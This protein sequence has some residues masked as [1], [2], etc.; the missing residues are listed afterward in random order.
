MKKNTTFTM[1][2]IAKRSQL[3]IIKSLFSSL[4]CFNVKKKVF[5]LYISLVGFSLSFSSD[6]AAF[7]VPAGTYYFDNSQTNWSNVYLFIG[8]GSYVISYQMTSSGNAPDVYS[9]NLLGLW[10]G[11]TGFFFANNSGGVTSGSSSYN[12]NTAIGAFPSNQPTVKSTTLGSAPA[13]GDAFV[14]YGT[15]ANFNMRQVSS[16]A[17]LTAPSAV[18][19][20]SNVMFYIFQDY[21]G[22]LGVTNNSS[23]SCIAT[24]QNVQFNSNKDNFIEMV[25]SNVP[26]PLSV[27]NNCNNWIGAGN[28]A[29]QTSGNAAGARYVTGTSNSKTNATSVT[30]SA[31][32]TS[33]AQGTAS[34]T[35]TASH[36]NNPTSS[37]GRNMYVQYYIGGTYYTSS[38][39]LTGTSTGVSL[40]TS[41]LAAGTY[42]IQS[43]ITDRIV[44]Y[45]TT[46]ITLTVTSTAPTITSTSSSITS[47][48]TQTYK[49]ATI[50]INGTNLSG[51]TTVKIGGSGGTACTNVTV[52]SSTQVT[53]I[54]PDGTSGGTIYVDNGTANTTSTDSYTN[55]GFISTTTGNWGTAS[56]WLGGTAPGTTSEATVANSHTVTLA[57]DATIA[58][59]TINS[60]GIFN[61]SS[62][63]LNIGSSGTITNNGTFTASTSTV[64]FAGAGTIAGTIAFNNLTLNGAVVFS[65]GTTV[66]GTLQLNASG[67]VSTNAPIYGSSSTLIYNQGGTPSFGNEWT[68]NST[69]AGAGVPKNVK[70][71]N[72]TTVNMPNSNRGIA[73]NIEISS[74]TLTL[75][76]TS[77]DIYVAG[78]WKRNNT[79]T[80]FTPNNRAVLFNG[81]GNSTIT[82]SGG[83][84]ETFNYFLIDKTSGNVILDNTVG[85]L[86]NCIVNA[87]AGNVFEIK[88]SGGLDLNGQTF[89]VSGSGGNLYGNGAQRNI[90]GT[91][92]G[93]FSV[94]AAKTVTGFG[95]TFGSNVTLAISSSFTF[96]TNLTIINGT[97]KLLSG[98]SLTNSPSYGNSSTLYYYSGGTPGRGVEWNA[99]SS[100]GYPYNVQIGNNTSLDVKNG[101][102]VYYKLG[103]NL[104]IESGST[105]NMNGLTVGASS[106]AVEVVGSIFNDGVINF[107][108]STKRLKC[109]HFTNG[110]T[111]TSATTNLSTLVG[112]DLELTGNFIDNATFNSNQR[113]V[114]FTGSGTQ[115][116]SGTA[117]APFNID[118]VVVAK[119]SGIVQMSQDLLVGAPSAGNAITLSSTS[120]IIDL[121]GKTLTIGT[122]SVA[123]SISGS[124]YFRGSSSSNIIINGTGAF[125]T[126]NFDQTTDGLTNMLGSF[127]IN[128]TSSGSVTL[129]NK[130]IVG[131]ACTLT[132]GQLILNNQALVLN[133]SL[134]ASSSNNFVG[135]STSTSTITIGGTGSLGTLYLD[136]TTNG[137]TNRIGS[138]IINRAGIT[139]TMGNKAILS[140]D[141][142]LS[143]GMLDLGSNT[144]DRASSGGTLTLAAGTTLKIGGTNTLP[145]NYSSHSINASSTVEYSGG[146]QSI[147]QLNSS[148]SYG[149]IVLSG[150]GTKTLSG[151]IS[152][153]ANWTRNTG[154][155]FAHASK[156]VTFTGSV[157]SSII[158]PNSSSRDIYGVFGGETFYDL[159]INKSSK[160]VTV[161]TGL[162]ASANNI[163][164]RRTL[165]ITTGTLN[166]GDSNV[167][168]ISRSD[169]TADLAPVNS[170]NAAVVY[171]GSGRF[172][173][174]RFVPNPTNVRTWRFLTA[175][176]QAD[177]PLTIQNAWQGGVSAGD[178]W[179]GYGITITGAGAT[180]NGFDASPLNKYSIEWYNNTGSTDVWGYPANTNVPLMSRSGWGVFIRGSRSAAVSGPYNLAD[181]V[182][183]EP[184]GK[185]NIGD[186]T[187]TVKPLRY[188]L[189]GNPYPAQISMT[190]VIAG[191][192]P[193]P[194]FKLWDPKAF[195]SYSQ[196]GKYILVYYDLAENPT[197]GWMVDNSPVTSWTT[198]GTIESGEAFLLDNTV[199]ATTLTFHESD[200][201]TGV[202]TTNGISSRPSGP[203]STASTFFAKLGFYN[204]STLN[205][206]YIDGTKNVYHPSYSSSV[207]A[208]ED[209]ISPTTSA[210]TIRIAK[211]GYQ[212]Y[213]DKEPSVNVGDT[214]FFSTNMAQ[215]NHR[216]ALYSK[217]F[218]TNVEPWAIDRY[219][220]NEVA[221]KVNDTDSTFIDFSVTSDAQSSRLDRF[222]VVFRPLSTVP[223][224]FVKVNAAHQPSGNSIEWVVDNQVNT[225]KYEVERSFDGV[226]FVSFQ[227]IDATAGNIY[228]TFDQG[229]FQSDVFYR[230]KLVGTGNNVAY[231]PIVKVRVANI[232]STIAVYPNPLVS[233]DKIDLQLINCEKGDY[234]I[235]LYNNLGQIILNK[236]INHLGG[237]SVETLS[238]SNI[239]LRGIYKLEVIN[240]KTM[241]TEIIN[242]SY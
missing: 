140:N 138:L 223:V 72:S 57:A 157:N 226:S 24:V 73:G 162:G 13:S 175:P 128:R 148:Q 158:A 71:Q 36:A 14:P 194:R 206:D 186:T 65:S 225:R 152:V 120:D 100:W 15:G 45:K 182:V 122:A 131:T 211:D 235:H 21:G 90:T 188:N 6:V 35:M 166:I 66:N 145:V 163:A 98:Y 119:S 170:S 42:T 159:T 133:G 22:T 227:S 142:T 8:H 41:G 43:V 7:N 96:G 229:N 154:T 220:G 18:V 191:S 231:S 183:L 187:V 196:T 105:F 237:S 40:N 49:G 106:I 130:L 113:A 209:Y 107:S 110:N 104:T 238:L 86:T 62:Y 208:T 20:G 30:T 103:G 31:S 234:R 94:T 222:I 46:N 102:D 135:S 77:G 67:S 109:F 108:G 112:G 155:T 178:P 87:T 189:I 3:D 193:H 44:Y 228:K 180:T 202:S 111:N 214:I 16:N 190:G 118:Y 69:T 201:Q 82:I 134:S 70:I 74:G 198:P 230:I 147:S 23:S 59:L 215:G 88:N 210:G 80:T 52:V 221:V 123:C 89:T 10:S 218:D 9:Y 197:T 169:A 165:D 177:D 141:L 173:V 125:G 219:T 93:T 144:I 39:K 81:A 174:Q 224:R 200:K 25:A 179:P 149:N 192:N 132:S 95:F 114:F 11:A 116:I 117:S 204:S 85:S 32:S 99:T 91:G 29:S 171:S 56:T 161:G 2:T 53:A 1:Q 79:G 195:S 126:V 199:N 236:S 239:L 33:I 63:T 37:Y 68:G 58:Q 172:S 47:N 216:L 12:I 4:F 48:N 241:K 5:V 212:L 78:N 167:V 76:A 181:D 51:I 55:L 185:I 143:A 27:T 127:T 207:I 240:T 50:T 146:N 61:A 156:K 124:G 75:N 17:N 203:A 97:L 19:S 115:T 164:I 233:G 26:T 232:K 242:I 84:T 101:S 137:T 64:V 139:V 213:I 92:G 168:L 205:Y 176:L 121:N 151:D 38:A 60:G 34:I 54:V 153:A 160:S 184:K 136:Q 150:T 83:G 217:N 28:F 129:G